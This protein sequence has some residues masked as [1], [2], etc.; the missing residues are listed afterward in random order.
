MYNLKGVHLNA[1]EAKYCLFNSKKIERFM[2]P[3]CFFL[4]II[5]INYLQ[6]FNVFKIGNVTGN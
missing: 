5:R 6:A 2:R 4:Q 1:G 3:V